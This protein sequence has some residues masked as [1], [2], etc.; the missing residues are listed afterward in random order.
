MTN[1]TLQVKL[2]LNGTKDSSLT[3][4]LE[5]LEVHAQ[6]DIKMHLHSIGE[7]LDMVVIVRVQQILRSFWK[8]TVVLL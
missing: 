5:I 6:L 4:K 7:D 2:Y 3:L 1:I 8:L